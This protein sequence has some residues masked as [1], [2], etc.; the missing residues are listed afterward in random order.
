MRAE[1]RLDFLTHLEK[2]TD[3]V[4]TADVISMVEPMDDD[5]YELFLEIQ[6][7]G[8]GPIPNALDMMARKFDVFAQLNPS[9]RRAH[10]AACGH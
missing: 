2:L 10:D 9:M 4:V 3:S 1:M 6:K 5:G 8:Y 7:L